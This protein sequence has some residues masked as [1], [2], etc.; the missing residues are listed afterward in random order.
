MVATLLV[1]TRT[2]QVTI[3]SATIR[4]TL[5][6]LTVKGLGGGDWAERWFVTVSTGILVVRFYK[7]NVK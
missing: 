5:R 7:S 4:R 6:P 3:K 1:A 2:P